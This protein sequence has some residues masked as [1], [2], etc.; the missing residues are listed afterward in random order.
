M[1]APLPASAAPEG[2]AGRDGHEGGA[3]RAGPVGVVGLGL[4]GSALAGRLADRGI[5]VV[6]FDLRPEARR[7]FVAGQRSD[8]PPCTA[9][10]S[11]AALSCQVTAVVLA[12]FDT[13]DVLQVVE[14]PG[15]LLGAGSRV[16]AVI[17]C[18]TGD[19]DA[20]QALAG[21][22]HDR[23]IDL[24][25]APLSG[26]SEQIA[27][28]VATMLLGGAAPAIARQVTILEALSPRRIHVGDAGFGARAKLATNL[29]LGLNRAV[30]AEGMVFASRLGIAPQAFLDLVLA[31]PARSAAAEAKGA[32]MVS[33]RFD[34]PQ[35]RIRQHLKDVRM[36]LAQAEAIGQPLP[37]S[38]AHADLMAA[39]V[40]AGDGDLDNAG[41]I[42][43]WLRMAD[44]DLNAA[45]A[46]A[47]RPPSNPTQEDPDA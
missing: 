16:T 12:V 28:G 27:G 41:L 38:A 20:L 13:R 2:S 42:R 43:Q 35:S 47:G 21:R 11:L 3:G 45:P 29:V 46:Q 44:P 32:L 18:S 24:I 23:G 17:D 10:D 26:S 33:G 25:E 39:A 37:L 19:P 6:G 7:R 5:A 31:T 1:A 15:G 22:L 14:A 34:A 9:V 30:L 36:M 8:A 40:A 4:V